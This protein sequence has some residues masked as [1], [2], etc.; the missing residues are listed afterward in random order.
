MSLKKRLDTIFEAKELKGSL[1]KPWGVLYTRPNP[2]NSRKKCENCMM[3][4]RNL[5]QCEIHASNIMVTADHVCGYHVFGKPH[6]DRMHHDDNVALQPV[7]PATS[8]LELVKGG[9][10]CDNC[11]YFNRIDKS[12]GKCKVVQIDGEHAIVDAKG[13]CARWDSK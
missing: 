9:T 12:K 4:I 5:K 11:E 3:W 2:D 13:C 10:S 8:G 7:D 1:P 6:N